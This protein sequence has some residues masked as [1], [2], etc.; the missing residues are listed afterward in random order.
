MFYML[1]INV[2]LWLY[3]GKGGIEKHGGVWK[4]QR[5]KWQRGRREITLDVTGA[6]MVKYH[7]YIDPEHQW[8]TSVERYRRLFYLAKHMIMVVYQGYEY[9]FR[10]S[11]KTFSHIFVSLCYLQRTVS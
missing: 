6:G 5:W 11:T 8:P 2:V 3:K 4:D 1:K 9:E 10:I 7:Q